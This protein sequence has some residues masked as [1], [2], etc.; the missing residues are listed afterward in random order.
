MIRMAFHPLLAVLYFFSIWTAAS[1]EPLKVYILAGQSNMQGKP[2]VH[3]LRHGLKDSSETRHLHD[4]LVDDEGEPR[5]FEEVHVAAVTDGPNEKSGPLTVGFGNDLTDKRGLRWGPELAFGA[6]LFEELQEPIL[7]I[8]TAWG[9]KN[10]HTD[11]LSPSGAEA[12]EGKETGLYYQRMLA[13][14][15]K[16]LGNPGNYH[17]EYDPRQGYEIEGFVWFQGWNDMADKK[18]YPE[19]QPDRYALYSELLTHFIRDVR[20]DLD[21]PKMPF[22]IGLMGVGGEDFRAA[23]AAPAAMDEFKGSVIA[24]NTYDFIDPKLWELVDRSWRWQRPKWDPEKKYTELREK[25]MPLQKKLNES[26]N[27]KDRDERIAAQ[28]DIKAQ[29]ESIQYTPD[30]LEYLKNNKS[31]QGFHYNGSPKFFARAGAGFAKALLE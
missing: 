3:V 4:L 2:N 24:V 22:V 29:M 27:I 10:L 28:R 1:A 5:V 25:L 15:E 12:S 20:K 23:M 26:K 30:E 9:G 16:V 31:S 7:I 17:P 13:H 18:V 14:I 11:F 6:T 21:V 19:G 8:K